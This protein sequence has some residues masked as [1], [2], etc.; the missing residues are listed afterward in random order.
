MFNPLKFI[1]E[2]LSRKL[3]A[4]GFLAM[5]VGAAVFV[6]HT[7]RTVE[8]NTQ[9]EARA[10][11]EGMQLLLK[12][13][14]STKLF[15]RDVS[16]AKTALDELISHSALNLLYVI[17]FD[18]DKKIFIS[19]GNTVG[20]TTQ[21]PKDLGS[22]PSTDNLMD[23]TFEEGHSHHYKVDLKLGNLV[24]GSAQFGLSFKALVETQRKLL[25][26]E[27][28]VL[29]VFLIIA[30]ALI[31]IISHILIRHLGELK[32]GAHAVAEGDY[33]VV[34]PIRTSDE[35]GE[36]TK[37]FNR[38]ASAIKDRTQT[39]RQFSR[40]IEQGPISVT[41]TDP[42]GNIEYVNPK[43]E[44]K[45]GYTADEV[46]GKNPR[47]LKSGIMPEETYKD[48]WETI[49]AGNEWKG[50]L[51]NKSKNGEIYWEHV[52]IA[53][54]R[55]NDGKITHYVAI[56]EDI[57]EQRQLRE[58]LDYQNRALNLIA[59]GQ[60][61][62]LEGKSASL[63]MEQFLKGILDLT[64]SEYGFIGEIHE[65]EDGT[66]YLRT[67]AITNIAWNE[68]T[69]SF[70]EANKRQGLEFRNLD[71]L[72]GAVIKTGEPVIVNDPETDLRTGGL[73]LGHPDLNSFLGLPFNIGGQ[74]VGMMGI[75][76]RPG[77]YDEDMVRKV[78]PITFAT[79][80]LV[81]A[82]RAR[83]ERQELATAHIES[84]AKVRSIIDNFIDGVISI[85]GEGIVQTFN[86][87]AARIF[88]YGP[89]EVIGQDISML[90]PM[91]DAASHQG[92]IENFLK[93]GTAKIIGIG[94]EVLGL[95]KN[96]VEF[97]LFLS[98]SETK[99]PDWDSEDH[100]SD[101]R[102][103]FIGTV[104]D[105]TE[106]KHTEE[107]LRRSQKME[108][109]GQLTGGIA[110]DFNN[111]LSIIIG[112]L[113]L[114]EEELESNSE[115][116]PPLETALK[117]SLRG[118]ATTKK[119]L[120]FSRQTTQSFSPLDVNAAIQNMD[121]MLAKSLTAEINIKMDLQDGLWLTEI[122]PGDL[123]DAIINLAINAR[124]AMPN[125]GDLIIE[126]TNKELGDSY[127]E[128]NP[129]VATGNY[130]MVSVSDSG[131]VMSKETLD[132]LF[133]PFFTTKAQGEGTGLGLSMV[134]GFVKRSKGHIKVY[135]RP[136][137]GSTF[138]LYLPQAQGL[139]KDTHSTPTDNETLLGGNETILIV[140][141][142][143]ELASLAQASL[144]KLGYETFV[145]EDASIAQ[146]ILNKEE[147]IDLLFSDVV[148]PGE[149]NGLDFAIQAI[150]Q[151]PELKVLMTSGFTQKLITDKKY[152]ALIKEMLVKPY[153]RPEL[154]K[155]I[156]ETLDA[157]KR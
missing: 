20:A 154:A 74:L 98:I 60:R 5:L 10:R 23:G 82:I 130:V 89:E 85:T 93:T 51:C 136:G 129:E 46:T 9:V 116:Y 66:R 56:K 49:S 68:E 142:E 67:Q 150:E 43:F 58:D 6:S 96:G 153:R 137:Q 118:A 155:R 81:Y 99:L 128:M 105:L 145:A 100:A 28:T 157:G 91:P 22:F 88:G 83:R 2:S 107:A 111:L 25:L 123:G 11:I 7:M 29:G 40:V 94:R 8:Y 44:E 125:G 50:E 132:K 32:R 19:A 156:R 104:Q 57:T 24:V 41:I 42:D 101:H 122:D 151:H 61:A 138:R 18:D 36:L 17:V 14:L 90:M 120:A 12:S 133:E 33:S 119:L 102:R 141:D 106:R 16:S 131:E 76:N 114:L 146:E 143:K 109:V 78:A 4:T 112:N 127:V 63:A 1:R 97:P 134:Y 13:T 3:L 65:E 95:R 124:D 77:G 38:M 86:P 152:S 110:H 69:T 126:T 26:K 148:M 70:Y 30:A 73:P 31:S 79:A 75:A 21:L 39:L 27:W 45:S 117:A 140:D 64:E 113:D 87:A 53:P 71:T 80:S 121:D 48:L 52:T 92:Y 144:A 108:A 34:L 72:F 115:L 55:G 35:I 54:L 149:M 37:D 103:I 139:A 62:F 135:S 15:A 84:E 47:I 147:R 59:E